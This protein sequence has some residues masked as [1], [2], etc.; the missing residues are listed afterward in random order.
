MWTRKVCMVQVQA[1][2]L[3][4]DCQDGGI[5]VID[6]GGGAC[7]SLWSACV[8]RSSSMWERDF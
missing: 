4:V 6:E 2:G 1:H 3:R 8:S 7:L 5:D